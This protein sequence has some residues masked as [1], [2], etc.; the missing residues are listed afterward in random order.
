M[1]TKRGLTLAMADLSCRLDLLEAAVTGLRQ[2]VKGLEWL[3]DADAA[4]AVVLPGQE[5][6][7]DATGRS[8]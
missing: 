8:L 5:P 2:D 6:L 3:V 1:W 7:S 4:R